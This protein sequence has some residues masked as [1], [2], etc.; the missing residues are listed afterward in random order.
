MPKNERKISMLWN[1]SGSE[2]LQQQI[3]TLC[4]RHSASL[5]LVA[6]GQRV[7][8]LSSHGVEYPNPIFEDQASFPADDGD[9]EYCEFQLNNIKVEHHPK[10]RIP[11]KV[12]AFGD[13]KHHPVHHSLW[14]A[15]EPDAQPWRPFKSRLEFDVAEIALKA[16]LNNEQTDRLLDICRCCVQQSE[17]FMFHNHKDI[18]AKWDAASQHLTGFMK[19][20]IS[21]PF[22]DKSWDFDVYYRDLW[23]WATDLLHNPDLF[24]H[25]HFNAQCLS[26]F[27]G[28]LFKQFV[29]EPFT[30]QH[31]WDAQLQ[32][33]GDAKPLAFILYADK[34]K[35]SSFGTAKGYPVVAHLANLPTDIHNSQ[36]MG[37]GY[38]VGWL[39]VMKEDKQHSGKPAWANFKATVWHKSFERILSSLA[40][41]SKMGQWLEC[42]D[43]VQ[44]WFFPLVLIL[45]SDFEEQLMMSL[46]HGVRSLWP[47]P[48][49]LVTAREK[50]TTEEREEV[51]K[52]YGLCDV[53]NSFW[54]LSSTDVHRALSWDKLHFHSG[55][56]WSDHLWVEL[57][58]HLSSI[59]LL[60]RSETSK[61]DNSVHKD[62][63]KRQ[64]VLLVT[65]SSIVSIFTL[66][67]T[68][69]LQL[70]MDLHIFDDVEAKGAMRNYNTK[71]NKKMHGSLKDSYLLH[72]NFHDIAE[73]TFDA[74]EAAHQDN[75]A[76][77][78]FRVKL[79]NFLDVLL[80]SSNIPLPEGK[81]IHLRGTN[82]VTEHR[83]IHINYKS[84]VDW[85]QHT[86]YL[87]C[88]P[89]FFGSPRFDCIFIQLTENKVILGRLIFCF[90]YLVGDRRFPLALI[91]P[92]DAPTGLRPRKDKDLN[93]FRARARPR[94]QA[95]FFSVRSIIHGALLIPDGPSDYLIVDTADT[96]M[97]LRMK[98][99]HLEAGHIWP[100]YY[101]HEMVHG[102]SSTGHSMSRRV[103]WPGQFPTINIHKGQQ[104]DNQPV[105]QPTG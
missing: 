4:L 22:T 6:T 53:L 69:L 30:A 76:F 54:T 23:E 10:S 13:F 72:T 67:L 75:Q 26:K 52:G 29:D 15:P 1:Q 11:T 19:N 104:L 51:L 85:C 68:S 5:A 9:L 88:N 92:F 48:A 102:M 7:P 86:D 34:T 40:E 82:E 64:T 57:Q 44:H 70:H 99:M 65:C 37:G 81:H 73:Q 21:V 96:D 43:A 45:S 62:I 27:N 18:R 101:N 41:K 46:T 8:S 28:Q 38:I 25:F 66:G 47:C 77:G 83:F 74:I 31:F 63:S 84:M 60:A 36:G 97:F 94:A 71:P 98:M 14:S 87:H 16:A 39:P 100:Y 59:S 2:K 58:K 80:P 89:L 3:Q 61:P 42:L 78:N 17:K 32:L 24:P 50:E 79:N 55:S 103:Y 33:P 105:S 56:E 12:E 93:L 20:V 90:E 35:L 91:H 49:I 95:Q